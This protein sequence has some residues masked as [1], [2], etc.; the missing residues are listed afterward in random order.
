MIK[1]TTGVNI[2]SV[3]ENIPPELAE[4]PQWVCWRYEECANGPTK[5]PYVP[6]TERRASSTDLMTWATC[7][8]ALSAYEVGEPPYDGVGFV[9]SSADPYVG[10]DLDDCRNPKSGEIAP[11]AKKIIARVQEGYIEISPS[12]EGIHVIIEGTLRGGRTQKKIKPSGK[13]EMYS[14][15]RFFTI[16]GRVL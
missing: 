6:G 7:D 14:R 4:R 3:E 12:G 5:V 16:S 15:E 10:I 9:F 11:W 13:I 8:V 2:S 1:E